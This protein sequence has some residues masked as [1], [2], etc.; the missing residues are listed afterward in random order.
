MYY[1]PVN[2]ANKLLLFVYLCNR[3]FNHTALMLTGRIFLWRYTHRFG[4]R[5][6]KIA[7]VLKSAQKT[8]LC[9]R[10]SIRQQPFRH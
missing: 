3:Q 6:Q 1:L 9:H 4:K 7:V 5:F 2:L 8:G 10:I